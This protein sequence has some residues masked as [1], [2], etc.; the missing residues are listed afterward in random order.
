MIGERN[1]M[2]KSTYCVVTKTKQTTPPK[3]NSKTLEQTK[4]IS[5]DG[6]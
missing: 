4:L 2:Q 5:N 3:K 6:K 1:K